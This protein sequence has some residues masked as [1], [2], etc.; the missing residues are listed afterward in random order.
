MKS[1]TAA[2]VAHGQ[3]CVY[4]SL[5]CVQANCSKVAGPQLICAQPFVVAHVTPST[6]QAVILVPSTELHVLSLSEK[7]T[8]T[9]YSGN[10]NNKAVVKVCRFQLGETFPNIVNSDFT[11]YLSSPLKFCGDGFRVLPPSLIDADKMLPSLTHPNVIYASGVGI[12]NY[13]ACDMVSVKSELNPS[14]VDFAVVVSLPSD[15]AST[16]NPSG[17]LADILNSKPGHC[18]VSNREYLA[19]SV[20]SLTSL[21]EQQIRHSRHVDIFLQNDDLDWLMDGSKQYELYNI[22]QEMISIYPIV[23]SDEGRSVRITVAG[24]HLMIRLVPAGI[25]SRPNHRRYCFVTDVNCDF[26]LK[27]DHNTA[28]NTAVDLSEPENYGLMSSVQSS[29]I[30]CHS[31]VIDELTSWVRYC[32]SHKK[33]GHS[34][35]LGPDGCGKTSITTLLAG[36]LARSSCACFCT[37]IECSGWK[38]KQSETIEK[39]LA[40]EVQKLS[41]RKPSLLILDDFDFIETSNEEEHRQIDVEKIFQMLLRLLSSCTIPVLVTAKQLKFIHKSL[42]VLSGRRLFAVVVHV[43]PLSQFM[44]YNPLVCLESEVSKISNP[45][46]PGSKE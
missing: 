16:G 5:R 4:T 33:F 46:A 7:T 20:I 28:H 22:L 26:K 3:G 11:G 32:W 18:I 35:L 25:S 34:L 42:V 38:G 24:R 10:I 27:V 2:T 43:P 40:S 13:T 8:N 44:A 36:K 6:N 12:S 41:H 17:S 39:S 37:R 15:S 31:D 21:K 19:Y 9:P 45:Q 29:N 1:F 23:L 30:E 14:T